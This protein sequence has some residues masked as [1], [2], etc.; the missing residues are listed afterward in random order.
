[1]SHQELL[2]P[3]DVQGLPLQGRHIIEA[4]AGTGKTFNI[5]K[6]Y[7][8]LLL[9][10]QLE[11]QQIL[12]VTFTKAAT[13]ELRGRIAAEIRDV[14]TAKRG[15]FELNK[16]EPDQS[17]QQQIL[18][19]EKALLHM[20]EAAVST[21]HGFCKLALQSQPYL[22]GIPPNAELEADCSDLLIDSIADW[23]RALS[24][25]QL[26]LLKVKDPDK[27]YS[28]YR[29]AI[30]NL[31]PIL[32]PLDETQIAAKQ[33]A[34]KQ[35]LLQ[36]LL[37]LTNEIEQVLVNDAAANQ[38]KKRAAEWQ[39]ISEFLNDDMALDNE[40]LEILCGF[41]RQ[42]R[43]FSSDDQQALNKVTPLF[44]KQSGI[45][46]LM[47]KVYSLRKQLD[48]SPAYQLLCDGIEHIRNEYAKRKLDAGRLD[49]NDLVSLLSQK[50]QQPDAKPLIEALAAQYPV[51]LVDEFQD[52]DAEQFGIFNALYPGGNPAQALFMIGDPKQ[53]I[54]RFR[55]GDIFTYLA[56][57]ESADYRWVMD[58]NWRSSAQMITAYNALFLAS[59]EQQVFG[60]GI[61]YAAVNFPPADKQKSPA[62]NVLDANSNMQALNFIVDIAG[63]EQEGKKLSAADKDTARQ[64]VV[65]GM[66]A[67]IAHLLNE[68]QLKHQPVQA[69]DIAV[70]V[71][72]AKL[73]N[74]VKEALAGRNINSVYLSDRQSV[75]KS[76]EANELLLV[77][78]GL[79]NPNSDGKLVSALST[80]LM[81][82]N[83][84]QLFELQQAEND[85]LWQFKRDEMAELRHQWDVQG[86]LPTMMT[87]LH[88]YFIPD[89]HRHERSL[90]NILHLLE[91]LQKASQQFRYPAQLHNWFVQQKQLDKG[92]DSHEQRLES[93][94][95]LIRL[96]TLH[97]SKGLEYP[98][99]F[100]PFTTEI[101]DPT[102]AGNSAKACL[103]YYDHQ[104]QANR[105]SL[106]YDDEI[107][108]LVKQEDAA[109]RA[110]LLYVA[111]TRA[112]YRC[113][114]GVS[115]FDDEQHATP[116]GLLLNLQAGSTLVSRLEQLTA[117][118]AD[119]HLQFADELMQLLPAN[120]LP[121]QQAL[122]ELALS[123]FTRKLQDK[124]RI[125]S[126]SGLTR[127]SQAMRLDKKERTDTEAVPVIV[128]P[129]P[130]FSQLPL[131]FT[132]AKGAHAGNLLHDS[133]E[134]L[135]FS[136]RDIEHWQQA[137]KQPMADFAD[138]Q[139]QAE[140]LID[141]LQQALAAPLPALHPEQTEL[142]LQDLSRSQ[143]CRESEFYFSVSAPQAAALG[144]FLAG[145]RQSKHQH[146]PLPLPDELS[147][148]MHGFIDLIFE[149]QG[150]Y[151]VADY[152][153]THLGFALS[154]YH[155]QA[156][157]QDMQA[158]FYDLQYLIYLVALH[159][160]L[161]QCLPD[162]DP[163]QHLGGV[164]YLYLR[165]MHSQGREGIYARYIEPDWIAQ[166]DALLRGNNTGSHVS[167]SG[168][169]AGADL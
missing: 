49:I 71:P 151:F 22:N 163:Q 77:M 63:P 104:Q 143:T 147:G 127:V 58:T 132:L 29:D 74:I 60:Q 67:E 102:K 66:V 19:L 81:G 24:A 91:L 39:R 28:T 165:G 86:F 27:F 89:A 94:A 129:A 164:Y 119:M 133:L 100:V 9:E 37:P 114:L 5:T 45:E 48:D 152:K 1:M 44:D 125:S 15:E 130:D 154:D 156:I 23:L 136:S 6:L 138:E 16:T 128:Q 83:A 85:A 17:L 149:H 134:H 55:G 162:Y 47:G 52:T 160:H 4:S 115:Q 93:E 70:L 46:A 153:S 53:A 42:S 158:H 56:A 84:Q 12:V 31:I 106:Q 68:V 65:N 40:I 2:K 25:S 11:V 76:D 113:Y 96:V 117:Q 120:D 18:L 43:K 75:Y 3:L 80:R 64:N 90:T 34:Y 122:P 116:L 118:H 82:G 103:K 7:L 95:N 20:D 51:A 148:M 157:E 57:R 30:D 109:E 26:A 79:L 142:R 54:Y 92:G 137:L 88:R 8:R 161:E 112:E 131:R 36:Y 110:R 166:L 140:Q 111:V 10:K 123:E 121:I 141:W 126:F 87:L 59:G 124:W 14:L 155:H 99:V 13:E 108:R 21:I 159:R 78:E 145:F 150:R 35:Q 139:L 73:A 144:E 105:L 135:D 61:D 101:S 98:F 167:A 33:A 69:R 72:N 97:G 38:R 50:L 62:S 107:V 32:A 169:M 168:V 41:F 146:N